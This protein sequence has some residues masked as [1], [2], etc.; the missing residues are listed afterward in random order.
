VPLFEHP[1]TIQH[2]I[3]SNQSDH[4]IEQ[5]QCALQTTLT[6]HF[7]FFAAGKEGNTQILKNTQ[8]QQL[9]VFLSD[10]RFLPQL[11]LLPPSPA[12]L[13]LDLFITGE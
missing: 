8:M 2:H 3:S 1:Q 5:L 6:P 4:E 7:F 10:S 13:I 12:Q 11:L 9:L